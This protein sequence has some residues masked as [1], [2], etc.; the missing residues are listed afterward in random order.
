MKNIG[1]L[2]LLLISL[3]IINYSCGKQGGRNKDN[4]PKQTSIKKLKIGNLNC[5]IFKN[6]SNTQKE[7]FIKKYKSQISD[8]VGKYYDKYRTIKQDSVIAKIY[9]IASAQNDS[10]LLPFYFY[11]IS[12]LAENKLNDGY[13]GELYPDYY[14]NLFLNNYYYLYYY[15][16]FNDKNH[17]GDKGENIASNISFILSN[18]NTS[19][20]ELDSILQI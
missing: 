8:Y 16:Y 19:K 13:L 5:I 1:F 20:L 15:L 12:E 2:Y 11:V 17:L 14:Y 4:F 18:K 9:N 10:I 7:N 6:L 3:M